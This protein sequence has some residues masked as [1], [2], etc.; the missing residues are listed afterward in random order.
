M[1]GHIN[2]KSKLLRHLVGLLFTYSNDARSHEHEIQKSNL[3]KIRAVG[4]EPF[5]AE[6]QTDWQ[7]DVTKLIVAFFKSCESA[8]KVNENRQMEADRLVKCW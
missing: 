4:A 7:T 2:M 1:Q 3:M 5:H 6:G 8:Y